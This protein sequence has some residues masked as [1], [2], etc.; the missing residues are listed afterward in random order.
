MP[1]LIF[2]LKL[3]L[4]GLEDRELFAIG[5]RTMDD[6]PKLIGLRKQFDRLT[7]KFRETAR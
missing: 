5:S 6:A 3:L 4:G 1:N 2:G 7:Q